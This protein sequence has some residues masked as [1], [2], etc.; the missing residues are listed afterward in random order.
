MR[1]FYQ[2]GMD[3]WGGIQTGP[4]GG[5]HFHYVAAIGQVGT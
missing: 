5:V 4:Q 1:H 2:A 3:L